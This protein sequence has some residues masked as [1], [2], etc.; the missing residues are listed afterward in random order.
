MLAQVTE[1]RTALHSEKLDRERAEAEFTERAERAEREAAEA[2][3]EAA[4]GEAGLRRELERTKEVRI[5]MQCNPLYRER[6]EGLN[7]VA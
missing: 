5:M 3:S 7:V 2:A 1:L 4:A 6:L